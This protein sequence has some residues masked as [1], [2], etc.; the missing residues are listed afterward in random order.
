MRLL[1]KHCSQEEYIS[2]CIHQLPDCEDDCNVHV[3]PESDHE[4]PEEPDHEAGADRLT[5]TPVQAERTRL[6]VNNG[7]TTSYCTFTTG[8]IQ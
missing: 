3:E 7:N 4:E 5:S 1:G 6:V 8:S 2:Y